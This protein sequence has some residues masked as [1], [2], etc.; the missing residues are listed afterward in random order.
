MTVHWSHKTRVIQ[1]S[2]QECPAAYCLMSHLTR[3]GVQKPL[4]IR[5]G[6]VT[7]R[8]ETD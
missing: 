3:E 6:R 2:G 1:G 4:L 8:I 7:F 5:D